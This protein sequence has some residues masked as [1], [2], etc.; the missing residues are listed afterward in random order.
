MRFPAPQPLMGTAET[1]WLN[2][3]KRGADSADGAAWRAY[4]RRL[5]PPAAFA[6]HELRTPMALQRTI[7]EV[8][9]QDPHPTIDSLRRALERAIAAGEEQQRLVDSLL[10]L[11][12]ARHGLVDPGPFD[13]E[14]VVAAAVSRQADTAERAG[15]RIDCSLAAAPT[16]GSRDLAE[17]LVANLL[18]NAI[19]YNED[20][21]VVDVVVE[22]R[23]ADAYL[24]VTN[25]GHVVDP[26]DVGRLFEPFQRAS[27]GTGGCGTGLG[28]AIVEAVTSAHQG[29]VRAHARPSGGLQVEVR[30]PGQSMNRSASRVR[31]DMKNLNSR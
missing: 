28:L 8:A 26:G 21:G 22:M 13:M 10:T 12:G 6:C 11:A 5:V 2:D 17:R 3:S 16:F 9:I 25:D 15:V 18:D 7:M 4:G 30:L 23:Q 1:E 14:D 29:R 24:A 31:A 19:R 20:G 27:N